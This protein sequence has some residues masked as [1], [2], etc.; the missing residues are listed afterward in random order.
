MPE[1]RSNG[2]VH[3]HVACLAVFRL[4]HR[5]RAGREVDVLPFELQLLGLA[6]AGVDGD[7]DNGPAAA[8]WFGALAQS[9]TTGMRRS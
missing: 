2:I 6:Q 5:D 1:Q 8:E 3:R 9:F 7:R 4:R